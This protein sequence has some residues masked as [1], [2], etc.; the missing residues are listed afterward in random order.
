[1]DFK[2]YSGQLI[3]LIKQQKILFI[4]C[5]VI[6][7]MLSS[8]AGMTL[9]GNDTKYT[10]QG[11]NDF[12]SQ[13]AQALPQA[14]NQ[15]SQSL[16]AIPSPTN[17]PLTT[18]FIYVIQSFFKSPKNTPGQSGNSG[19]SYQSG[20][21][22]ALAPQNTVTGSTSSSGGNNS[23]GNGNNGGGSQTGNQQGN[24][25]NNL[26]IA[27]PTP[28][29]IT[30]VQIVFIDEN[31]NPWT[32][33]PPDVPPIDTTWTRYINHQD[34]YAIDYPTAWLMYK[35][36]YNGHEGI[37][38]YEPGGDPND[39]DKPS[40]AFVGWQADYLSSSAKFTGQITVKGYPGTIYTN[41]PVGSSSL[42][43]VFNYTGRYFAMGSS[44]SDPVFIY[45]FDHMLRSLEFNVE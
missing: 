9:I 39:I 5:A 22:N 43:A 14:G 32:Y 10:P 42:A 23:A 21:Q 28:T 31:G 19:S 36:N 40:I 4:I 12:Q 17:M 30:D 45:V 3:Q 25:Q 6:F 27:I 11:Q 16:P 2:K 29:P 35:S 37:T 7:I 13:T 44:I 24:G 20:S 18:K 34:H 38:L 41:G 8:L 15:A 1:M 26:P 33:V